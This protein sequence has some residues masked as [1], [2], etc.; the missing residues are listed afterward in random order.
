MPEAVGPAELFG[1][2]KCELHAEADA[3]HRGARA[4]A[5]AMSSSSPSSRRFSIA[6]GN[7]PDAGEHEPVAR[8]AA[9]VVVASTSARRADVLERLLDRAPVAHPVVDDRDVAAP[10]LERAHP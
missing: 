9:R 7:A 8:R 4:H 6:R 5:L 2:V 3:E 10:S 1:A